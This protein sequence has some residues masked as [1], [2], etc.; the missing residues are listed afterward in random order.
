[1]SGP[2]DPQARGASFTGAPAAKA[3]QAVC[4]AASIATLACGAPGPSSSLPRAIAVAPAGVVAPGAVTV[5]VEFSGAID[6]RGVEDG[7]YFALCREQDLRDVLRAAES[8]EGLGPAAPVLA[9]RAMLEGG[10]TR[11]VLRPERPLDPETSWAAVLSHRTRSADGRPVLDLDGKARTVVVPFA[12]GPAVDR[13]GPVPRWVVPPHG[14]APANLG[15]LAIGFGEEVTG[16]LA[17]PLASATSTAGGAAGAAGSPVARSYS[18][19]PGVL[20]LDLSRP[21]SDGSLTVDVSGVRDAAGNAARPLDPLEVSACATAGLALAGEPRA[22]PGPAHVRVTAAIG[23]MGRLVAEATARAGDAPCGAV[24]PPPGALVAIGEVAPC[25]GWDPCTPGAVACPSTVELAGVCPG[26]PFRV[27][28]M[29]EDLAGNR[30]EP[31]PWLEVSAL[32]PEP[33]PVLTEVL[34]DADSPEAGG[35]YVEVANLGTGALELEGL[36]LAKQT[37]A[38]KHVR[39]SI[40]RHAGGPV[41]P[42]GHALVVGGAYDG[43]YALPPGIAVYRCGATSL[44]GGLAN[45]R[46]VALALE[47]SA[48]RVLSTAGIEEVA[49]RCLRGALERVHPAG[50]DAAGNWACPEVRTPGACNRSTPPAECPRR[51]W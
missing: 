1:M 47:D 22:E 23:G 19:S 15:S 12:T 16:E 3:A 51:S 7:R 8:A 49:P 4:L 26:Q 10:G 50:P 27:R 34:A 39:C 37:S 24:P 48:G 14:P 5:T 11:A 20:G 42:A 2:R 13:E 45:D 35:E 17:L 44:A 46:P 33:R 9:A 40:A 38:G 41:A 30:G 32:P 28:M 6:P 18:V 36:V 43:R 29:V 31:G 21:L 25:P